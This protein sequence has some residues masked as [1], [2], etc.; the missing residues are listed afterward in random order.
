MAKSVD[1]RGR[2]ARLARRDEGAYLLLC[3]WHAACDLSH[4]SNRQ[5]NRA[6]EASGCD[7]LLGRDAL[8]D[9]G[10]QLGLRRLTPLGPSPARGGFAPRPGLR[11]PAR[12]A[13]EGR[14]HARP[15]RDAQ[16][17]EQPICPPRLKRRQTRKKEIPGTRPRI[18]V[19]WDWVDGHAKRARAVTAFGVAD[20]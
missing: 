14:E 1:D 13:A 11:A 4:D 12:A 8:L 7:A 15:H 19:L 18:S 9:Y 6:V 16:R 17:E 20:G 10:A 3:N 5:R 2:G